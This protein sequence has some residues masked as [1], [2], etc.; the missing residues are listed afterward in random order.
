MNRGEGEEREIQLTIESCILFPSIGIEKKE[1][2]SGIFRIDSSIDLKLL[3]FDLK[4]L[5]DD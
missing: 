5:L 4:L 2:R 3:D 1:K